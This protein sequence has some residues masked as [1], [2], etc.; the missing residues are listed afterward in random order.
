MSEILKDCR[1]VDSHDAGVLIVAIDHM[2]DNRENMIK[3]LKRRGEPKGVI[4]IQT[5]STPDSVPNM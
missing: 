4:D 1:C 2:R 3:E 5:R